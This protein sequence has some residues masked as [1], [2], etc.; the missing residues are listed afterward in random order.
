MEKEREGE[1]KGGD[2]RKI[3][4]K[5]EGRLKRERREAMRETKEKAKGKEGGMKGKK[6]GMK[7]KRREEKEGIRV[8]Y[9]AE[10]K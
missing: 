8:M 10:A 1:Q 2:R 5:K 9:A 7:R 3:K 4:M 6:K